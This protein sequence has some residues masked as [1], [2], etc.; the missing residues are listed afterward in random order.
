[1]WPAWLIAAYLSY[2]KGNF[3]KLISA[4]EIIGLFSP[5]VTALYIIFSSDNSELK[6]DFY[7][8]LVNLGSIRPSTI[9]AMFLIMPATVVISVT[10]SNVFFEQSANQLMFV[11]GSAFAAGIIPAQ[12][13]LVLAPL[14]EELGWRGYGVESLRG[15]RSFLS[16]TL[17]FAAM[18]AFW[19][20]PLFF[21]NNYY[22]NTLIRTNP[23]FAINFFVSMFATAIIINWLWYKN[24]GSILTAI[25]FHAAADVQG[26]L[27]MGQVAKC[28]QT[29]ILVIIA[30]TILKSDKK[31][32]FSAFPARIGYYG[33]GE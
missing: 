22:Q 30:I 9:P 11:K 28:I 33:E 2:Q 29:V 20:I 15:N 6:Q 27:L 26:M 31:I 8:R 1:M 18:W 21:V 12:A 7:R 24:K 17:I 25:I 5:L 23:L 32:F 13:L 4:L 10:I 19:H 3:D 16:A 14:V